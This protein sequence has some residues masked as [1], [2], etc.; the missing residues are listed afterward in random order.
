MTTIF[1]NSDYEGFLSWSQT[2]TIFFANSGYEIVSST[3]EWVFRGT[4][5]K[6]FI[7]KSSYDEC[8]RELELSIFEMRQLNF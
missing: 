7:L 8:L 6:F 5:L 4:A 1:V 3:P 2:M